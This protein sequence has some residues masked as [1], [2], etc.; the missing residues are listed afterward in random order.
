M[1]E[2]L[3]DER[4]A[5]KLVHSNRRALGFN[6]L[7]L[8]SSAEKPAAFIDFRAFENLST[9]VLADKLTIDEIL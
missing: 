1:C 9:K 5:K 7:H 8:P 3:G 2:P 4:A 6:A